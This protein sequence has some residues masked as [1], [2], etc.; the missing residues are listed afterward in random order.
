MSI[1]LFALGRWVIDD[2]QIIRFTIKI[3]VHGF[4]SVILCGPSA[5]I[6]KNIG[7]SCERLNKIVSRLN[8]TPT[9]TFLQRHTNVLFNL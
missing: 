9:V 2:N 7:V 1:N 4:A 8:L 3:I 6:F 5:M